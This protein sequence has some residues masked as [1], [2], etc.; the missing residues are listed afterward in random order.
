MAQSRS[1]EG[2]D[3]PTPPNGM[4]VIDPGA[5]AET[6]PH[7]FNSLGD[8]ISAEDVGSAAPSV[9]GAP[10]PAQPRG[11]AQDWPKLEYRSRNKPE[12]SKR[13]SPL[14]FFRRKES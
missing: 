14:D 10:E 13:P 4:P 3:A 7:G 2:S 12:R 8:V 11:E 5:D 6:P 1:F 9:F